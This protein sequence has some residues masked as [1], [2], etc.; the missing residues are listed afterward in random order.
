MRIERCGVCHS[1][2]HMQDGYFVLGG[3]KKLDVRAGRT[4]PFT[5][6]H[7]IAGTVEGAGPDSDTKSGARVAVYPWIGC[8]QCAA[9]KVGD[10]N[11]CTAPRHLGT[12]VDG[13]FATYVLVPHPRYLIDYAPLP[14]G[15]AGALMCSGLTAYSALKRLADRAARAPLLLIGL[16][17]VGLTGLALARA[18]YGTA[19]FVA[20]IDPK[21]REAALAAGAAE[22]FDPSDPNARKALLK[23]SGGIYAAC[24]F[25][26]SD[27]SLN[28]ATG[29]L[30]KGGKVV[31]T[32]LIGGAYSTAVAMFPLKAMTIEGTMTGTLAEARELIDLVRAKKI[33]PP[34]LAE[35]PLAQ[36]SAT[37]DDLRAGRIVGRVVLTA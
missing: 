37:L 23:A 8:G 3:D 12:T 32:G 11:I 14:A 13:G 4:L 35:R 22:A 6:G 20:D 15:Y 27:A 21:K 26:G 24:D 28:F 18:M 19:P 29:V 25:A 36:A 31:V 1:D 2:L 5:L 34:P 30:A 10:E 16:G 9:C 33:A 7:E 17:G